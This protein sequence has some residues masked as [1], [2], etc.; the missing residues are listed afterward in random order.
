ML[1]KK[2]GLAILFILLCG[3]FSACTGISEEKSECSVVAT[4]FPPYDFVRQIAGDKVSLH[5]LLKPGVE[6]HTYEPTPQDIMTIK[7]C[8]VFIYTGGESDEWVRQILESI[9]TTHIKLISLVDL[10]DTVEE[11]G[12][13]GEADE[14]VWTSPRNAILITEAI[15]KIMQSVDVKNKETY[16]VKTKSYIAKLETL[17]EQFENLI[18]HA[19]RKKIVIGDRFPFRYFVEEY[20]LKYEA[21]F[22]GCAAESE[23]SAATVIRLITTVKKEKIPVVFYT[24]LSNHKTADT[25]AEAT[26]TKIKMFH[27]CH[28]VSA[29]EFER[30]ETYL[31][32]M[33]QNFE[34]MKQALQ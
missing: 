4:V 29:E 18:G 31:S 13:E 12:G 27:S 16:Q 1:K 8:D 17:D 2:I 22:P 34:S 11:D 24:E 19:K 21:A 23:A 3:L 25:I 32:L 6:S 33:E 9:D 10:V 15:S 28:N 30:R 20:G 5:M 7:N 14:H 26:G